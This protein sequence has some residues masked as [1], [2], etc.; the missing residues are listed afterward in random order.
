MSYDLTNHFALG[1]PEGIEED[2]YTLKAWQPN[3]KAKHEAVIEAFRN[4]EL[5]KYATVPMYYPNN[6]GVDVADMAAIEQATDELLKE[7]AS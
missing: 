6:F 2:G 7:L 4:D 3:G 1:P 5:V